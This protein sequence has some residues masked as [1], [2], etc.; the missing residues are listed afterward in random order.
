MSKRLTLNKAR[1]T[2]EDFAKTYLYYHELEPLDFLKYMDK[3][4]YIEAIIYS[5]DEIN[6]QQIDIDMDKK[7][8][9]TQSNNTQSIDKEYLSKTTES[10]LNRMLK[11]NQA[12]KILTSF[13]KKHD[14]Y[15]QRIENEIKDG[16]LYWKLETFLCNDNNWKT[17]Q[18]L[19]NE[20]LIQ[21]CISL[22]SFDYRLMNLVLYKILKQKYNDKH[23]LFLRCHELIIEIGDD[24]FDYEDDII[25]NSFNV[26]RMY[27]KLYLNQPKTA[28]LKLTQFISNTEKLY[29]LRQQDVD[30]SIVKLHESRNK[31]AWKGIVQS[32]DWIIPTPI[33]DEEKYRNQVIEIEQ[34]DNNQKLTQ[35]LLS[36]IDI[37]MK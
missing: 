23:L 22:K 17:Y 1:S 10:E 13:L 24:L 15:D 16:L 32:D 5:I 21:K 20:Q 14:I 6:E 36:H 8:N 33:I 2:L 34:L 12:L 35:Q 27:L 7:S 19:I 3:L 9:N 29:Q 25:K 18:N 11:K 26:L 31:T 37:N 4:I 30:S 28:I